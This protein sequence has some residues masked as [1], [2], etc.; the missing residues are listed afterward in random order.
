M[1][2]KSLNYWNK[3]NK[4]FTQNMTKRSKIITPP[5]EYIEAH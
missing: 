2:N 3:K 1:K 4:S 5:K